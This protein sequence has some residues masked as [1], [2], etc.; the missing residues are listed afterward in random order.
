M[1]DAFLLVFRNLKERKTRAALLKQWNSEA[2][3][4]N[5]FTLTLSKRAWFPHS[6]RIMH[7]MTLWLTKTFH[8][9]FLISGLPTI[10]CLT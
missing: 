3:Q 6:L 5:G 4:K 2:V 7:S 1:K 8:A 9:F 10:V